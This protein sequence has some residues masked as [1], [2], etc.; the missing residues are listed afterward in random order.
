MGVALAKLGTPTYHTL[1]ESYERGA[2]SEVGVGA[3][4]T[5][6]FLWETVKVPK[7]GFFAVFRLQRAKK[8]LQKLTMEKEEMGEKLKIKR[9]LHYPYWLQLMN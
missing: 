3:Q 2:T 4:V 1:I 6:V 7:M 9:T 8:I 5:R